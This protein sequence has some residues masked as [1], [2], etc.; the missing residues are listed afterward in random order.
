MARDAPRE[1]KGVFSGHTDSARSQGGRSLCPRG[2]RDGS[3]AVADVAALASRGNDQLAPAQP[4]GTVLGI[5]ERGPQGTSHGVRT[6]LSVRLRDLGTPRN[7]RAVHVERGVPASPL[8]IVRSRWTSSPEAKERKTSGEPLAQRPHYS[9]ARFLI[10]NN[11]NQD[12][13]KNS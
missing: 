1:P 10:T 8:A 3:V 12:T 2:L 5:P 11:K 7:T 9:G 4:Q 6:G 13:F